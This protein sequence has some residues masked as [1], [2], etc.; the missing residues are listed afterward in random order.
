MKKILITSML[1]AS[2]LLVACKENKKNAVDTQYDK[3][4]Q[5]STAEFK[6]PSAQYRIVP[7]WSWNETMEPDE[8]RRQL[9]LMKK[10]GWGGSM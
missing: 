10:A 1:C 5:F 8:I 2:L 6:N 3:N 9:R 7:F 4:S